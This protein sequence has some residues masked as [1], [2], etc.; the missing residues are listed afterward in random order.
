MRSLVFSG[1]IFDDSL[2]RYLF[3]FGVFE[4]EKTTKQTSLFILPDIICPL[5]EERK[6][7]QINLASF[8]DKELWVLF[9]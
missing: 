2:H 9:Q 1:I 6:N 4:R 7:I 8:G 5:L 3:C